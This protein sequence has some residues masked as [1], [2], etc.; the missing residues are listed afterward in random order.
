MNRTTAS[1]S[2]SG[3]GQ[4]LVE[5]ALLLPVLMLLIFG[6]IDAGRGIYIWNTVSQAAREG[7]RRGAVLASS[8]ARPGP[9]TVPYCPTSPADL[10]AQ[11]VTAANGMAVGLGQLTSPSNVTVQCQRTPGG[12]WA[13]CAWGS[14]DDRCFSTSNTCAGDLIRVTIT[15]PFS[16]LTPMIS[17]VFGNPTMGASATMVI[18]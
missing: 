4:S 9:C 15:Y 2:A 8:T 6:A 16:P 3:R 18:N 12:T 14:A 10:T 13:A 7:A 17:R 11:V 1:R 5:F